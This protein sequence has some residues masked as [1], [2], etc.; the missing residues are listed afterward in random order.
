[1]LKVKMLKIGFLLSPLVLCLIFGNPSGAVDCGGGIVSTVPGQYNPLP[2]LL[3][4][5][6]RPF[7][8]WLVFSKR[9][10]P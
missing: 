5:R 3:R 10:K 6:G 2:P 7:D 1:M 9:L 8:Y 4:F